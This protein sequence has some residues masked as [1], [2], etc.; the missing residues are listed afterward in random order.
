MASTLPNKNWQSYLCDDDDWQS[1]FVLICKPEQSGKTFIMIQQI[2]KDL[3]E[4]TDDK[5]VI[6]FIFCDNSLLLTKQTSERVKKDVE[7]FTIN[8]VS[9][10]EFSSRRGKKDTSKEDKEHAQNSDAVWKAITG[11]DEISN[12][13][14][15]T[16]GTRV[17]NI[18]LIIKQ[19]N[20]S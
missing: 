18:S 4:P 5:T 7:P 8:E 6:N 19:L 12:V 15:C 20:T 2:I 13:I 16:N 9:Y 1:K 17:A 10:V 14:C 3:E 11:P